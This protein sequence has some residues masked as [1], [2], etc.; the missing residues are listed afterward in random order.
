MEE[1]SREERNP[2]IVSNEWSCGTVRKAFYHLRIQHQIFVGKPTSCVSPEGS[3]LVE[4]YSPY[5]Q[6]TKGNFKGSYSERG[7]H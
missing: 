4:K 3:E 1:K 5:F 6:K 2:L 7:P